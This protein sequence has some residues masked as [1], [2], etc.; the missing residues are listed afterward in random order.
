MDNNRL[1]TVTIDGCKEYRISPYT[2]VIDLLDSLNLEAKDQIVGAL[3]NNHICDLNKPIGE[4]SNIKL[5]NK[6]S[7]AGIRIYRRSAAFILIKASRILFPKRQLIV[8]HSISNGLYCEFEDRDTSEYEIMALEE[9]MREIVKANYPIN[10]TVISKSEAL[11]IFNRQGQNDKVTLLCQRDKELVHVFELDGFYEYFYGYMV[12]NTNMICHFR[13]I[14]YGRGLILQTPEIDSPNMLKP[15]KAQEKLASIFKE[16]R[17][18]ADML[19]TPHVAA[20]NERIMENNI[21]DII[22]INEALHEK[23]IALIAD[24]ICQDRNKRIILISGPSSSGKTTF[25]QRLLIQLRVNGRRPVAVSLDNYFVDRELTPK[26][27][28]GNYDFEA[29]EA[30][31][32]DLFNEHLNLL[33]NGEAVEVPLFSFQKGTT[34]PE[35]VLLKVPTGEPIII[36]GIHALNDKLTFSIPVINK[37][38]I[39]VS[40]LTQLNIDYTNRIPTTDCRLLRRMIRDSRARG[41]DAIN[42]LNRWPSVRRGEEKNIFPFQENADVMFNTSLV[43]ELAVLKPYAEELLNAIGPENEEYGE[44]RRL[45]KFLSYFKVVAPDEIPPNSILREFIGGSWFKH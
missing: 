13:L 25:A 45:L 1:I 39:H 22:H 28:D 7:E 9:R 21:N 17:E 10:R 30:I 5:L 14:P 44:A 2:R 16:A 33:L 4:D 37:Y 15:Y 41:Y 24:E 19:E 6:T 18:W 3:V 26:D 12:P 38:R 20:L 31:K 23:K 43:Y 29:L 8:K 32:L 36:E 27:A 34:E 35:G 42:T 40:A 11:E